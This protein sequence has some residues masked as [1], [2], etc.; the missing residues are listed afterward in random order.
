MLEDADHVHTEACFLD[1]QPLLVVELFQSQ[2]CKFCVKNVP[3]IHDAVQHNTNIA[4]LTFNVTYFDRTEWQDTLAA[5]QWDSRQR[6]Y[7]TRWAR[8]SVYTPQVVFDGLVDGT[9]ASVSEMLELADKARQSK[10]QRGFNIILDAN[11][12]ELRIDSDRA[13]MPTHDI[14]LCYYEPK[15]QTVKIGKGVNKGKKLKHLNVV[16]MV[17]KVGEWQGGNLTLPFTLSPEAYDR[18]LSALGIV[19][20]PSGGPIVAAHQL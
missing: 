6:A 9:G 7:V 8:T 15:L 2:G 20:E 1:V 14:L 16:R 5:K 19:Q 10:S 18:G 17:T 4:L 13:E 3:K 11:D 12:T